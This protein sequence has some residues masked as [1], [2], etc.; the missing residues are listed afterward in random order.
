MTGIY[1]IKMMKIMTKMPFDGLLKNIQNQN[2]HV[3]DEMSK[4]PETSEAY[5]DEVEARLT[6]FY[7]KTTGNFEFPNNIE[8]DILRMMQHA[9]ELRRKE[10]H[11]DR[12]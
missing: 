5:L 12:R 3:G 6:Y 2:I 4:L 11:N 8:G 7:Y 9:L 10:K 1:F